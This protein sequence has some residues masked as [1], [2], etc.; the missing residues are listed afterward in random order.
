[1]FVL[2][3]C[4]PKHFWSF[5]DWVRRHH[6]RGRR[7]DQ[8]LTLSHLTISHI[9]FQILLTYWVANNSKSNDKSMTKKF[10]NFLFAC[11]GRR[12]R[13]CPI[14][15]FFLGLYGRILAINLYRAEEAARAA[16][17]LRIVKEMCHCVDGNKCSTSRDSYGVHKALI[18]L[19]YVPSKQPL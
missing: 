6:F 3:V 15:A 2:L 1:M 7:G 14:W 8:N 16:M 18:F 13:W 11:A 10:P 12:Q 17:T 9:L 5:Q 19:S 4:M